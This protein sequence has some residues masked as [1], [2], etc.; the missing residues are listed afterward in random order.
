MWRYEVPFIPVPNV[1]LYRLRYLV[2]GQQC[3]NTLYANV[4]DS[5]DPDQL[6]GTATRLFDWWAAELAPQAPNGVFLQDVQAVDL[7]FEDGPTFTYV[8]PTPSQG[9]Q[10]DTPSPNNVS[11]CISFSSA[12]RG[13]ASRGRN[14]FVGVPKGK[15]SESN[16]N[17]SWADAVVTAYKTLLGETVFEAGQQW[18][19]VSRYHGV[20][21][22]GNPIPRAEGI[23]YI[24]TA[25]KYTD[26]VIDSQR[27]RLPKRGK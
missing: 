12:A 6:E 11:F 14:Y 5:S 25:V 23:N 27:R 1:I 15:T 10:I 24:I 17:A 2:S 16:V 9:T 19:V 7:A 22:D 20:D 4:T 26:L 18:C 13:P 8:P 3:F 21:A